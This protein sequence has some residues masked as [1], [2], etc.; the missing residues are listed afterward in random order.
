MFILLAG[1]KK[2]N[3]TNIIQNPGQSEPY[4]KLQQQPEV[5]LPL[6]LTVHLSTFV[7]LIY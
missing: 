4:H 7:I 1:K 3:K 2:Q 6:L 5:L